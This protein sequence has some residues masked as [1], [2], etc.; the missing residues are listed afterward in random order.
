MMIGTFEISSEAFV[1]TIALI[2]TA[3]ISIMSLYRNERSRLIENI[4]KLYSLINRIEKVRYCLGLVN[5]R[6]RQVMKSFPHEIMINCGYQGITNDNELAVLQLQAKHLM[7]EIRRLKLVRLRILNL[8]QPQLR[9]LADACEAFMYYKDADIIWKR[10]LKKHFINEEIK[11]EYYRGYGQFLYSKILDYN[12]GDTYFRESLKMP[13]DN[14]GRCYIKFF[15]YLTWI[16][17]IIESESNIMNEIDLFEHN[18]SLLKELFQNARNVAQKNKKR[19]QR[20]DC[21][22]ELKVRENIL[23]EQRKRNYNTLIV[24]KINYS[25]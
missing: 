4:D 20:N 8:S 17:A 6:N 11:A 25:N 14:I 2:V 7:I 23:N 5:I 10:C 24:E 3:T 21:M 22:R 18:T 9:L 15:T 1:A 13:D 12:Q 19:L 16:D